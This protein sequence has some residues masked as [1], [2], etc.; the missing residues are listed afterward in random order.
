MGLLKIM[1]EKE[2]ARMTWNFPYYSKN[3][4]EEK[5]YALRI[6]R[7]R[8]YSEWGDFELSEMLH[9]ANDWK[10]GSGVQTKGQDNKAL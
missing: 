2:E 10:F 9:S 4:K 7:E 3:Q 6:E 5:E 8:K 1:R